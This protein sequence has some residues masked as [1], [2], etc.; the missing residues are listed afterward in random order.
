MDKFILTFDEDVAKKFTETG[1]QLI[2]HSGNSWVF[3]NNQKLL[4][5]IDPK[6]YVFTN[7]LTF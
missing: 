5:D 2:S 7:K 4:F 3:L 6:K 1:C